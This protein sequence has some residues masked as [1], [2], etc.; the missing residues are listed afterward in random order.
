MPAWGSSQLAVDP[1]GRHLCFGDIAA[2]KIRCVS[3]SDRTIQGYGTGLSGYAGDGGN[4]ADATFTTWRE[5][6]LTKALLG[7]RAEA[8]GVGAVQAALR[9]EGGDWRRE[10]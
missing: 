2:G 9:G 7:G 5:P 4:V 8:G 3:F 6:C 1:S 10:P